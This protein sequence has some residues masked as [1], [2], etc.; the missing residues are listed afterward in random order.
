MTHRGMTSVK[1]NM[2]KRAYGYYMIFREVSCLSFLSAKQEIICQK[3][4]YK[5]CHYLLALVLFHFNA[6]REEQEVS[7][8]DLVS[9]RIGDVGFAMYSMRLSPQW[10]LCGS[11]SIVVMKQPFPRSQVTPNFREW[12]RLNAEDLDKVRTTIH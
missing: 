6:F 3:T 2:G 10:Q 9:T 8:P 7:M 12:H 1:V 5:Y 4:K 11:H